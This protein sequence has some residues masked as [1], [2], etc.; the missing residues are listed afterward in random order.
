MENKRVDEN[1]N[2]CVC[3]GEFYEICKKKKERC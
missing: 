1:Q 2:E 3:V